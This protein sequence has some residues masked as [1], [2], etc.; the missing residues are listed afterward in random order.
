M[1]RALDDEDETLKAKAIQQWRLSLDLKPN[2]PNRERL[3]KYIEIYSK[4]NE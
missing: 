4:Q 2:Q 1:L 3:L